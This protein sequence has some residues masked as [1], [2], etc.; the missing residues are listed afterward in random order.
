[1]PEPPE[2]ETVLE[3]EFRLLA[4][5]QLDDAG[6][7]ISARMLITKNI[8]KNQIVFKLREKEAKVRCLQ[9]VISNLALNRD[10]P[11]TGNLLS[12]LLTPDEHFFAL[13]SYVMGIIEIGLENLFFAS[14]Y[15]SDEFNPNSSAGG[16][17]TNILWQ[18]Y[19]ALWS[20]VPILAFKMLQKLYK[21]VL[22]L[23]PKGWL[24]THNPLFFKEFVNFRAIRFRDPPLVQAMH[25]IIRSISLSTIFRD[26]TTDPS[27]REEIINN[28]FWDLPEPPQTHI[29]RLI[30]TLD[31]QWL[32]GTLQFKD[33]FGSSS[34]IPPSLRESILIFIWGIYN[35]NFAEFYKL[36]LSSVLNLPDR[37]IIKEIVIGHRDLK[38]SKNKNLRG[39]LPIYL[40]KIK[41]FIL[42]AKIAN[43]HLQK[44]RFCK[45]F[46]WESLNPICQLPYLQ[47]L[48]IFG[49]HLREL[50][51]NIGDLKSLKVLS[52]AENEI[53]TVTQNIAALTS[54]ERLTL[55]RNRLRALPKD[56]TLAKEQFLNLKELVLADNFITTVA[57]LASHLPALELLSL[58]RNQLESLPDSIGALKTLRHLSLSFNKIAFLPEAIGNLHSLKVL[59]L[60]QN[61]LSALPASIGKLSSLKRLS[62]DHNNL[63]TL[64]ATIGNLRAL[65]VLA[66]GHNQLSALPPEIGQLNKLR[67]LLLQGNHLTSL[68]PEIENLSSLNRLVLHSNQL[69]ALPEQIGNL[70]A[71]K[72]LDLRNNTLQTL[73]IS[74]K[75]LGA[76]QELYLTGNPFLADPPA[77]FQD[78]IASLMRIGCKV[79]LAPRVVPNKTHQMKG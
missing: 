41:K 22:A 52:V 46:Q 36:Y 51:L 13:K 5:P 70:I 21:K 47:F 10:E 57:N 3:S 19:Q 58:A 29:K 77:F 76:L 27:I 25:V 9:T 78:W 23:C 18:I 32:T 45:K 1:M 7:R 17:N 30:L 68:P 15:N 56:F 43:Q 75:K 55:S 42:E 67:V 48:E 11:A 37:D 62:L 33:L 34:P 71:L 2:A 6:I 31:H 79:H 8:V 38:L 26:K 24:E 16:F 53:E 66:L 50:P 44:V 61:R 73:P 4:D 59:G 65:E 39:L 49:V 28:I 12:R 63:T 14:N 69:H 35:F 74:V 72:I 54:L 40:D 60:N 20:L 64:P